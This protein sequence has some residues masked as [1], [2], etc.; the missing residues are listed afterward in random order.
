MYII[1]IFGYLVNILSGI[2]DITWMQGKV[3]QN[4]QIN[5]H[6]IYIDICFYL[7]PIAPRGFVMASTNLQNNPKGTVKV[8]QVAT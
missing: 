5:L 8:I 7:V 2:G 4:L 1:V 6:N 3:C